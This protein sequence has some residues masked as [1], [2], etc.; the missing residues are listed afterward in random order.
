MSIRSPIRPLARRWADNHDTRA[1]SREATGPLG[2]ELT[3][4]QPRSAS[5]KTRGKEH[6]PIERLIRIAPRRPLIA[7]SALVMFLLL[8][9]QPLRAQTCS[10][11]F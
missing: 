3:R 11:Q 4:E 6:G 7:L 5:G 10:R 1:T 2:R 8:L 9:S